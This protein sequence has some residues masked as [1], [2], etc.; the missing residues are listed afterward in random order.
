[1]EIAEIE[2][3]VAGGREIWGR[4]HESNKLERPAPGRGEIGGKKYL[5]AAV[6]EMALGIGPRR[7]MRSARMK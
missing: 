6:R 2:R 4:Y 5:F 7:A 1:M 3:H